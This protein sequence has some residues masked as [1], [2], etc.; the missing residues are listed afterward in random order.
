MHSPPDTPSVGVVAIELDPKSPLVGTY[1]ELGDGFVNSDSG[2]ALTITPTSRVTTLGH[3]RAAKAKRRVTQ[4]SSD[5]L[6]GKP[7]P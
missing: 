3:A 7:A 5:L 1:E 6:L 4:N 2:G